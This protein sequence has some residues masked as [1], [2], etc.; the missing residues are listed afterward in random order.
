[1]N[2]KD[3]N[4]LNQASTISRIMTF[5]TRKLASKPREGI[6]VSHNSLKQLNKCTSNFAKSK[7]D[8]QRFHFRNRFY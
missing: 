7:K 1:M 6:K 2:E 5:N 4:T 8:L 3:Q